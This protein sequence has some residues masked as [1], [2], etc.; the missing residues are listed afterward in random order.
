MEE[1]YTGYIKDKLKNCKNCGSVNLT[2]EQSLMMC[3]ITNEDG[4]IKAGL[5]GMAGI[6][7]IGIFCRDC[8]YFHLFSKNQIDRNL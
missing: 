1:K 4:K 5:S 6:S 8:G 3:P 7:L 2:G